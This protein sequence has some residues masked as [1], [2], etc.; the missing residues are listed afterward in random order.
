MQGNSTIY[1]C[2]VTASHCPSKQTQSR[3]RLAQLGKWTKQPSV[4]PVEPVQWR[5]GPPGTARLGSSRETNRP[6]SSFT[7][8]L[9]HNT[10]SSGYMDP[11]AHSLGESGCSKPA[12]ATLARAKFMMSITRMKSN[13]ERGSPW[14]KSWW[15]SWSFGFLPSTAAKINPVHW[16]LNFLLYLFLDVETCAIDSVLC[17]IDLAS[18]VI[19]VTWFNETKELDTSY[20]QVCTTIWAVE[21]TCFSESDYFLRVWYYLCI[22]LAQRWL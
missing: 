21:L 15:W 7:T 11:D 10:T 22:L 5:P 20:R 19:E 6:S 12:S 13:G 2:K 18:C 17:E 16:N 8:G 4:A 9:K 3:P 14:L 1:W